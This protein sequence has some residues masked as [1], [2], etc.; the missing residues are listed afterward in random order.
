MKS[1]AERSARVAIAAALILLAGAA[2]AGQR[3]LGFEMRQAFRGITLDGVYGDGTFFTETYVADGTIEYR[4]A[5]GADTGK[6]SISGETFCT[7]YE[8]RAGACF[9]VQRD[10]ANCFSFYEATDTGGATKVWT[11]RGW[12]RASHAT[13]PE[14]PG[15]E[16]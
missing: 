5:E 16:V 6:W 14:A 3:M 9:F 8:R 12:N 7:F 13:C 4:D 1:T 15:A 10:G 2:D 11:S